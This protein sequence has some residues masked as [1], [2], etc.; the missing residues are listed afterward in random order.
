MSDSYSSNSTGSISSSDIEEQD[1]IDLCGLILN[2]KYVIIEEIGAGASASV[3]V[4]YNI[5]RNMFYAIKVQNSE[6][7]DEGLEEVEQ[8]KRINKAGCKYLTRLI[9]SF[10]YKSEYGEHVCMV[11]N[12]KACSLDDII[13]VSEGKYATGLSFKTATEIIYQLLISVHSLHDK[14]KIMHTDIKPENILV[15][16]VGNSAKYIISKFID[17]NLDKKIK[18]KITKSRRRGL[19]SENIVSELI[20][21]VYDNSSSEDNEIIDDKYITNP[22]ISLSDFGNAILF[23]ENTYEEIQTRHYR[24][25]EVILGCEYNYKSDIWSIAC[26]YY[27]LLTGDI[28]F[29]PKKTRGVSTDRQHIYDIQKLLGK[30]PDNILN[31][32]HKRDVFFRR[33]GLMKGRKIIQYHSL[34]LFLQHKLKDK[35]NM[36]N[37]DIENVIEFMINIMNYD[38]DNRPS[39]IQ[40]LSYPLF[41]IYNN[42]IKKNN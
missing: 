32:S 34:K 39:A 31:K 8:L 38:Y 41:N 1:D 18:K 26:V 21:E 5:D 11:F 15:S 13:N 14:C 20:K 35:K 33:N 23:S 2:K 30:I 40:C 29:Y 3:W 7:I 37:N 12:L 9:D 36:T 28:L 42:T 27:E 19:M 24:A 4:A 25:P 6:D 10:L 16:G 22:E 17:N